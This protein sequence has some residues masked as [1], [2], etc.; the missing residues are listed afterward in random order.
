VPAGE[1]LVAIDENT[2]VVG[3]GERWKVMGAGGAHVWR[4]DAWTD[5]PPGARFTLTLPRE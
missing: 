1:L 4:D 5:H 3:D 2:A